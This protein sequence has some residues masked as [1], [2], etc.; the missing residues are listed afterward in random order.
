[1]KKIFLLT[2]LSVFLLS[3]FSQVSVGYTE[4]IYKVSFNKSIEDEEIQRLPY[5]WGFLRAFLYKY[6]NVVF[7]PNGDV[8]VTCSGWGLKMCAPIY[9]GMLPEV[10]GVEPQVIENTC[11]D[12]ITDYDE[13]VVNGVPVGTT[14]KKIA[15]ADPQSGGR[16]A[17]LLFQL[18]WN[19]DPQKPY[20]GRAEITISKT[21]D[22]GF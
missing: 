10:M 6:V 5:Y 2:L 16:T 15:F 20:N 4:P 9:R 18:N 7:L 12:M 19:H 21:N 3:A 8:Q 17:Y 11:E 22:L 1:M 13:Q 14:T